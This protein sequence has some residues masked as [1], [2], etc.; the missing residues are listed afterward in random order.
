MKIST[1]ARY[2]TRLMVALGA[3]YGQRPVFLKEIAK[4]EEISEKYL[5]QIIMPLK[6]AGLVNSFRGAHGGYVLSRA[7]AQ[8]S[9]KDIVG[10]LEGDF[11]L[12]GCVGNPSE[13]S[14][15]SICVTRDLWSKLGRQISEMLK[16]V[17]LEDLVKRFKEKRQTSLMY[18]I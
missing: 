8:I 11:N 5:S 10:V 9:L 14:R 1:R 16:T 3:H 6:A 13:C 2:G 15:V 4:A 12:V 17:T 18:A 7:P